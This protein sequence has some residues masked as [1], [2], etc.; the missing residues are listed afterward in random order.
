[1]ATGFSPPRMAD[2]PSTEGVIEELVVAAEQQQQALQAAT[3][4]TAVVLEQGLSRTRELIQQLEGRGSSAAVQHELHRPLLKVP[5][6]MPGWVPDRVKEVFGTPISVKQAI[7][8]G[9]CGNAASAASSTGVS[10]AYPSVAPQPA[11]RPSLLTRALSV[12]IMGGS[13]ASS[14]APAPSPFAAVLSST[15]AGGSR[16]AW[17]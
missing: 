15:S 1:M 8:D 10:H 2:S 16:P 17:R 6:A 7:V 13:G 12:T 5:D 9:A 3:G 11:P 4:R 14:S